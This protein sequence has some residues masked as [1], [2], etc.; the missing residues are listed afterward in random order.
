MVE[1][2]IHALEALLQRVRVRDVPLDEFYAACPGY[3]IYIF[4]EP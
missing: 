4:P 1:H 2:I 3:L